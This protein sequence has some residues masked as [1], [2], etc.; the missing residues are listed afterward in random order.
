MCWHFF[1]P[2]NLV[3]G[4]ALAQTWL[5]HYSVHLECQ[6][7]PFLFTSCKPKCPSNRFKC[8]PCFGK[9]CFFTTPKLN[10][11]IPSW[12]YRLQ[13]QRCLW[14]EKMQHLGH[15]ID[16]N[17]KIKWWMF[18][19]VRHQWFVSPFN[20]FPDFCVFSGERPRNRPKIIKIAGAG[21]AMVSQQMIRLDVVLPSGR[22]EK[23]DLEECSTVRELRTLV[24]E[25]GQIGDSPG[26]S[27]FEKAEKIG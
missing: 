8:K 3:L 18:H 2:W 11:W 14:S 16:L 19:D 17:V 15:A 26:E 27:T 23:L 13:N 24:T 20:W 1:F 25:L 21:E 5:N 6:L 10:V 7:S 12:N 9:T 4:M 22:S